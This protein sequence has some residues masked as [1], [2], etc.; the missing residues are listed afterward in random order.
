MGVAV[1]KGQNFQ[2]MEELV[3]IKSPRMRLLAEELN[4]MPKTFVDALSNLN[5]NHDF[6][7]LLNGNPKDITDALGVIAEPASHLGGWDAGIDQ[8]GGTKTWEIRFPQG[9]C[10]QLVGTDSPNLDGQLGIPLITQKQIDADIA[11]Y[12]Q[13]SIQYS[14]MDLGKMPR[15]AAAR[16][17]ITRQMCFKFHAM[18]DPVWEGTQRTRIGCLDA[19]Y[20]GTGGDR[21]VFGEL[22]F[23]PEAK[24]ASGE[25]LAS[26]IVTQTTPRRDTNQI[27]ALIE[28]MVVP[29]VDR[30]KEMPEDQ[31]VL[32]VK[33][34]CEKRGIAP[35]NFFFD[36]TGRGSLMNSFG[37]LWS[38]HVNGIEFGGTA[39]ANRRIDPFVVAHT[40]GSTDTVL[41]KDY[42]FN[43]VTELWFNL[44]YVIQ[45]GQFRGLTEEVM[46]EASMRE[47]GFA[48]KKIQAEP[49]DKMKQKSGRSPDLADC[50]VVGVAGAIKR[51]FV[52]K[53]T[54]STMH[55]RVDHSWKRKLKERAQ[56]HWRD[57]E[58]VFK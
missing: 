26:A 7:A 20:R 42:Y 17:I 53:R 40:N 16:R 50:L 14:M 8:T 36:S 30:P 22:Q 18:E 3:G 23:G 9:V 49:K 38:P 25:E 31:I 28:T 29:V 47:W 45:S 13:D 33:E 1:K 12:G 39:S 48:G 24:G 56:N 57:G 6:K 10:M 35:E 55:K 11:F 41:C 43:M 34:Q 37:R 32:W 52:I 21:C 4:F 58:L 19:A 44:S 5:K 46:N 2:G 51:G 15:G 54:Q 27:L